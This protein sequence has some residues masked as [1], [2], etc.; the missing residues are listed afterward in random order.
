VHLP[1]FL[2]DLLTAHRDHHP[3]APFVFTGANGGLHRHA[4]FRQRL[5][6]PALAGNPARGLPP[7]Q[8]E[9]HFHDLRHTHETWLVEDQVPRVLRLQRLGHKRKDIDDFYAHV[10]PAIRA[11]T[12][13]ALQQRWEHSG[14]QGAAQILEPGPDAA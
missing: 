1:P 2:A 10:T 9:M 11:K 8:P 5:W 7:I 13:T 4:N 12:L 6:Q 3:D 14:G